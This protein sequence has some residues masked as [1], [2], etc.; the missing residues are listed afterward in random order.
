MIGVLL[1]YLALAGAMLLPIIGLGFWQLSDMTIDWML[2]T[3]MALLIAVFIGSLMHPGHATGVI[4]RHLERQR[5]VLTVLAVG[6]IVVSLRLLIK[7]QQFRLRI[8]VD[9]PLLIAAVL[10][11]L[12][13]AALVCTGLTSLLAGGLRS[14]L[15]GST[16][17]RN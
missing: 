13:A 6:G 17:R 15:R 7:F 5:A 9:W 16:S 10:L 12:L 3:A 2:L 14:A 8:D 4:G 11:W 1:G